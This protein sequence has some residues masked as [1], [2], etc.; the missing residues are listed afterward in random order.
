MSCPSYGRQNFFA[1]SQQLRKKKI[2][3]I[4]KLCCF[5]CPSSSLL[6]RLNIFLWDISKTALMASKNF[7]NAFQCV[8]RH[9]GERAVY[10]VALNNSLLVQA[11]PVLSLSAS[12]LA[13][14]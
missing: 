9:A 7:Q 6:D 11:S 2:K 3:K 8:V 4:W 13:A 10:V 12:F 1:L 14:M 5:V